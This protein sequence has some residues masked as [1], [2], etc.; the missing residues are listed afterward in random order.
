MAIPDC[1]ALCSSLDKDSLIR[2]YFENGYAYKDIRTFLESKH[3]IVLSEDQLRGRLKR[4]GLKRRGNE[5]TLEEVEA[6]IQVSKNA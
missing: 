5:S 3:G 2:K 1:P 4:L 6:A